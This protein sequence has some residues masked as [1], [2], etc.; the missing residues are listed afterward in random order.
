[1]SRVILD[2]PPPLDELVRSRADQEGIPVDEYVVREMERATSIPSEHDLW[3]RLKQLPP[4]PLGE[5]GAE[6]VRA[7]RE[8]RMQY[9]DELFD[10][11]WNRR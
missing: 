3:E 6:L 5:S 8:E 9:L 11:L 10:D 4:V 1:M 2:F 7:G